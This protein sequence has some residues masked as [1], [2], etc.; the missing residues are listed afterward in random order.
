ML[1]EHGALL[2]Q[3]LLYLSLFL[4]RHRDEYYRRLTAVR[5]EGAWE[6]WLDFFLDGVATIADEAV[7]SAR[8][9]FA[10]VAEGRAR[11]LAVGGTSIAAVRL[12]ELLPRHPLVTVQATAS[13]L[14]IS[15][16]TAVRAI[17]AL[18]AADVLRET[19]GKKRDRL[20]AYHGYL[21]RLRVGTDLDARRR[22][23]R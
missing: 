2:S 23:A 15:K 1:L 16:P 9:L 20:Y 6:A 17:E 11:V 14:A 5:L 10:L 21:E 3:P 7:I 4:K 13:W 8:E 18:V 19:T 22:S 12:F